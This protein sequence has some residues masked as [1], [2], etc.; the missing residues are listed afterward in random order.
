M[1]EQ[2]IELLGQQMEDRVT[3]FKGMVDSVS[4]DVYGCVQATL[5]P[6]VDKDGNVPDGNWF[7]V[8]RLKKVGKRLMDVPAHMITPPG[9]ENGPADKPMR[10][11]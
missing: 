9:S 11:A 3:G 10:R 2:H 1:I 4:F 5:R 7:D 6:R 8:K